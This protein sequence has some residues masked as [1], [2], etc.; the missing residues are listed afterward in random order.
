MSQCMSKVFWLELLPKWSCHQLRCGSCRWSRLSGEEGRSGVQFGYITLTNKWGKPEGN[1]ISE[2]GVQQ[3]GLDR[4]H[5]LGVSIQMIIYGFLFFY[6]VQKCSYIQYI[7]LLHPFNNDQ[8][9]A[10]LTLYFSIYVSSYFVCLNKP[11][12]SWRHLVASLPNISA[13]LTGI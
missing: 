5:N 4:K 7:Y 6:H 3:R 9:F 12:E 8:H 1:W 13:F 2:S 11:F 10:I